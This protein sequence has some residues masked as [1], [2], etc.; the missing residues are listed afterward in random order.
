MDTVE[1]RVEPDFEFDLAGRVRN[2]SLPASPVNALIP[3]F[4]AVSNALH[5]VEA[6][7]GDRTT[8]S[9]R[10]EI[11]V[12]RRDGVETGSVQGFT[13]RD[14]GIGL[15]KDNWDSFRTSD[16]AFKVSRG[17]KG[18]GRLAWLKAFG[19]CEIVSR[20]GEPN[21]TIRRSFT[22]ALR[23]GKNPIHAHKLVRDE[24]GER[25]GTTVR[26]HPF[27]VNF[28]AH[29]PKRTTT[30]AAKLVGHFLTYFAVG[31]VPTMTLVDG[32]EIIDLV[33]YYSENQ[34]R[35]EIDIVEVKLDPASEPL[36]FQVYHVLL[37]K[38][39]K[40]LE[41]GLHWLFFA[42]N[43]RVAE[44]DA[45]DGQLGLRYVGEGEDCVYVGLVTGTYLDGHVNQERTGFSFGKE[46][47]A[48]IH[49]AAIISAKAFLGQY[50]SRIREEQLGT[51]DDIIRA[52]PQFL[53]F[54]EA[55]SDFVSAHLPLNAQSEEEVFLVLSRQKL[56]AKRRLDGQLRALQREGPDGMDESVQKITK[57][58]ND[59]KKSSLAEYV[60][61]RKSI[62]EVLDSS[63]AFKDPEKRRHYREEVIHELIVPLRTNSED[64]DYTQHNLW[65][66]DD[67]LAFYTFFRSDKP[68][69]TFTDAASGKEPDLAII[70]EQ[71]LAF[72]RE[73]RDE[74]VV[75]VEFKRPGRDDYDGNSNPVTQV[76]E[77]VDLF[78]A[79]KAVQDKNGRLVKSIS[80]ATRFVCYIVADFTD[81]LKRVLRYSPANHPTAD[82]Q[83]FFGVSTEHNA[84]IEVLPYEK[85]LQDARVRNEAFFRHLGLD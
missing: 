84:S 38:Q 22:F 4:E 54:R 35:S 23:K 68:F 77:Y 30:L 50:I 32:G 14:N 82:G 51:A 46:W 28:E 9:G 18:V 29:C 25:C 45:I 72:R 75:I 61:R 78:R 20:F 11:E 15:N 27:H 6:E 43:E 13:V 76:L 55:L 1:A 24:A 60:V 73:G 53:Q 63:L 79:G 47:M 66:L 57:A 70:F 3:L 34:Q 59:E 85:I 56:R 8:A 62:L 52:N 16:S 41:A 17:G 10:I 19:N 37:R 39:L 58:L 21:A 33:R 71:S 49:K 26:L 36:E 65:I 80:E 69:R 64:L 12:H 67:R 5:A 44:Q 81:S 48:E 2:L 42:G 7:W 74:P 40:F 31:K 83:G